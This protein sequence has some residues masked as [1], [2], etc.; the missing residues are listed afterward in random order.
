MTSQEIILAFLAT[1]AS[2]SILKPIAKVL[3]WVDKPGGRKHHVK[4]TPIIGG[5][6]MLWGSLRGVWG[7]SRALKARSLPHA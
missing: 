5:P 6:A 2:V 1:A 7:F 4:V 3:K